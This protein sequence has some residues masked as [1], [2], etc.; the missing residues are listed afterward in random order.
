MSKKHCDY[1]GE[2]LGCVPAYHYGPVTCGEPECEKWAQELE[3]AQMEEAQWDA[4]EDGYSLYGG[5]G[6][7]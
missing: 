2:D 5:P 1:C 4:A 3:Q 6:R 7:W